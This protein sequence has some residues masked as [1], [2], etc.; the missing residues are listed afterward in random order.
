MYFGRKENL[1]RLYLSAYSGGNSGGI[2]TTK[3]SELTLPECAR[4][5]SISWVQA[6]RLVLTG[7]LKARQ[8]GT[9]YFVDSADLERAR[10]ERAT[11]GNAHAAALVAATRE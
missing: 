2:V 10:H 8:I 3:K 5:L 7:K 9:R 11:E 4:A 6:Y 1:A